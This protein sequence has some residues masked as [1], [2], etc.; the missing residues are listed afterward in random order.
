M[1]ILGKASLRKLENVGNPC[2]NS[3]APKLFKIG[4][5][6]QQPRLGRIPNA[7][8]N[9]MAI[10]IW[11]E[12][13]FTWQLTSCIAPFYQ[14]KRKKV[15]KTMNI[16]SSTLTPKIVLFSMSEF[17]V[18][19]VKNWVFKIR[20]YWTG[21][22]NISWNIPDLERKR[23]RSHFCYCSSSELC[24]HSVSVLLTLLCDVHVC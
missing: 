19:S 18:H 11:L 21:G 23:R 12:F 22:R 15:Q 13:V 10:D 4:M 6:G 17:V 8:M 24:L 1:K 2:M 14:P 9:D 16:S 3:K 7:K 20:D 5:A